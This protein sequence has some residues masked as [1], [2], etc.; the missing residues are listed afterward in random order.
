MKETKNEKSTPVTPPSEWE[1]ED[2]LKVS[3]CR[4]PTPSSDTS[5]K[6]GTSAG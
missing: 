1:P 6:I 5:Q 3:R 2:W 4:F